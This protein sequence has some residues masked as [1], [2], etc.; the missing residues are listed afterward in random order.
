MI[1]KIYSLVLAAISILLFSPAIYAESPNQE[2]PDI[3]SKAAIM[4]EADTEQVLFAKN[5]TKEMYPASL[6]K[7]ATAIYAIENGSLDDMVTISSNA[8]EVDGTTV[9]LVEGE[10][11]SLKKLIQGM[12]I[13]SGNDASVAIAE[14]LSGSVEQ[15]SKDINSY[16]RQFVGVQNTNFKNPHGLFHPEHVTTAEDMAKI[17]Q[18]AARNN[19]FM[20]IFS[21]K[22]LEWNGETWD[23][24]IQTHHKLLKG[25][26]PYEGVTGGKNGFVSQ[27]GYTLATMAE[28]DDLNLI[29]VTLNSNFKDEPYQDTIKLLDYGFGNFENSKIEEGTR[30]QTGNQEYIT[31]ETIIYTHA[32]DEK[33]SEEIK[34]G[35]ILQLEDDL[36]TSTFPLEKIEEENEKQLDSASVDNSAPASQGNENSG[37]TIWIYLLGIAAVTCTAYVFWKK[38]AF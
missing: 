27:S 7:I 16:L 11:V 30:F 23:T 24:T 26:F 21:T 1:N 28:Q 36:T 14:H 35:G 5:E 18:Y 3:V 8:V 15:F 33:S 22:E 38:R 34:E 10:K 29:V 9:F 25:E 37:P 20:D 6:T 4:M 32:S 2:P 19:V 13:N 31:T 17:T 12:L